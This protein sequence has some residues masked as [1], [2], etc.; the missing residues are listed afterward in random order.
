MADYSNTSIPQ[1][2]NWQDFE[3]NTRILFECIL[4]DRSVQTNGRPGQRQ[5]GVDIFGRENGKGVRWI[6]V[7]CKGKNRSYGGK[8][9]ENELRKEVNETRNFVPELTEFYL[10][11]TAPDDAEIQKVARIITDER[12][13][14][15]KPL[16][17]SVLGWEQLEA[18]IAEHP[19]AIQVFHPDLSVFSNK[20]FEGIEYLK[21]KGDVTEQ[22]FQ[23]LESKI[24]ALTRSVNASDG[25][26]ASEEAHDGVLHKQIDGYRDLINEGKPET[27]LK[28]LNSL[29]DEIWEEASDRIRFRILTN[30]AS[31]TLKLGQT[32]EEEAAQLFI[33]AYSYQPE[34]KRAL[35]NLAL[36]H[37]F[38]GDY[39]EAKIICRQAL[40]LDASNLEAASYLIQLSAKD[41]TVD[42]PSALVAQKLL[43]EASIDLAIINF[44]R[45]RN[46]E[47]WIDFSRDSLARHGDNESIRRSAAE[48]ELDSAVKKIGISTGERPDE[49][50]DYERLNEAGEVLQTAWNEQYQSESPSSDRSL[51][52]NLVLLYRVIENEEM[53]LRTLNQ[54]LEKIPESRDLL[55]L[56]LNRLFESGDLEAA[57]E[58]LP[59]LE[60]DIESILMLAELQSHDFPQKALEILRNIDQQVDILPRHRILAAGLR[61][62]SWLSSKD[63]Q[64]EERIENANKELA[65]VSAL[66]PDSIPV[67]LMNSQ[68][69]EEVGSG[70]ELVEVMTALKAQVNEE[71]EFYDRF[72]VAR[73]L[74]SLRLFG[75]AADLLEGRVDLSYN[76]PPLRTLIVSSINSDRRS[77]AFKILNQLPEHIST[78]PIYLEAARCLHIRRGDYDSALEVIDKLIQ[79]TPTNLYLTLCKLD[80]YIRR[81]DT[82]SV[83]EILETDIES[84]DGTPHEFMRV[85]HILDRFRYHERALQLGY[86]T[87]LSNINNDQVQLAYIGLLLKPGSSDSKNLLAQQIAEDI[88]FTSTN[89]KGKTETFILEANEKF[90]SLEEAIPLDHP[91]AIA[92]MGLKVGDSYQDK[93]GKGWTVTSIKHKYLYLLH[94][95]MESFGRRFPDN[96]GLKKVE[97]EEVDGEKSFEPL[98]SQVKDRHDSIEELIHFYTNNPLPLQI[99]QQ[100]IA[101]DIVS[102]WQVIANSKN[103]FRVCYG[104]HQ[105]RDDAVASITK[106]KARGCVV[107]ALTLHI[108]RVLEIC[109]VV[110]SICGPI[111]TTESTVDVFR[112]RH[113]T[114]VAHEGKPY[115]TVFWENGE[116]FRDEVTA[117]RLAQMVGEREEV[118]NWIEEEVTIIPAETEKPLSKEAESIRDSVSFDFLDPMIAAEGS[119]LLFLCEDMYYRQI[120][121]SFFTVSATWLQ[122]VLQVAVLENKLSMDRYV[123]I[124][125]QLVGAGHDFISIDSHVLACAFDIDKDCFESVS[126]ALFSENT[127]LESHKRVMLEFLELIWRPSQSL[128]PPVRAQAATSVILRRLFGSA[129]NKGDDKAS[130][131]QLTYLLSPILRDRKFKS[132]LSDWLRGHFLA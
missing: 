59:Q 63:I 36:A 50:I 83:N 43:G 54:A 66:Y 17:V 39:E 1:P 96:E 45:T 38:L 29:K 131:E 48:A 77:S 21:E 123:Q 34:D 11:T 23:A 10:I 109:D 120:G 44:Y 32:N 88:A 47:T 53:E 20:V 106:N 132:Y 104:L 30:I 56:K 94:S 114:A 125:G 117:E 92:S 2:K 74:E 64:K 5:N 115:F 101:E 99:F 128:F 33:E 40:E 97:I 3:R 116:F 8:V 16:T 22:R 52:Y 28:L 81:R 4:N 87:L 7:Q 12:T 57:R 37:N 111:H 75:D 18:R 105:E 6:G 89:K 31:A 80:I 85:A 55:K 129:W 19:R 41:D 110:T 130:V 126:K 35:S 121:T 122:P 93:D 9:T 112:L 46:D 61:I 13:K 60:D 71:T 49:P 15:G 58:L 62:D 27:A 24:E 113:E 72:M 91:V 69:L 25:V 107:D 90:R 108:L 42:D 95:K 79:T 70:D 76:S 78:L 84:L 118:L 103:T 14:E 67:K 124:V 65:T 26:Q 68:I 127:E 73:R 51:P 86:K 102:A 119:E 82:D 100:W 98:L